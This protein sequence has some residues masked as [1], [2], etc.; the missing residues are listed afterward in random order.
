MKYDFISVM[1]RR[2]KDALAVDGIGK[3]VWGYE[4]ALP[5]EGFDIIPMWVADM[6]FPTAPAITEAISERLSHPAFG[7]FEPRKEYFDSVISWQERRNGVRNLTPEAIGYENGVLGGVLSALNTFCS[8]GDSVLL[9]SPTYIGFSGALKNN[10][11][12]MVFS[13]LKQDDSGIWRMDLAD[14]EKKIR[15]EHIHAFLFCSPHNPTG[16]V[17]DPEELSGLSALLEKYEVRIVSDEIW[18]DLILGD[19]PHIPFQSVSAYTRKNTVALY[20]PSKTFNLAGLI[21]SYHIIYD[22]VLRERVE[23]E[24]SLCSYNEMNVLSMYALI[25]AYS[26]GGEEWLEELLA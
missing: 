16:R 2:G 24:S 5:E 17:W 21:G 7:Y 22:R 15:Q 10:G 9:H 20:A 25:G 18:S 1:D 12:R 6:N 23:K 3:T 19:K 4:P 13:P 26:H 14:M 8:R 11:F